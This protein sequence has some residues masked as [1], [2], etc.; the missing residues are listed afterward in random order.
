MPARP[1][2]EPAPDVAAA[3]NGGEVVELVE[4]TGARKPLHDAERKRGAANAAAGDAERSPRIVILASVE[5]AVEMCQAN[6]AQL[7]N[8]AGEC[9]IDDAAV[10]LLLTLVSLL[11]TLVRRAFR[12]LIVVGDHRLAGVGQR[13]RVAQLLHRSVDDEIIKRRDDTLHR[14]DV[15]I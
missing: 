9:G 11:L 13:A 8:R 10:D 4:N 5:L 1:G 7:A 6:V 12:V 15:A 2:R 14:L 3:G